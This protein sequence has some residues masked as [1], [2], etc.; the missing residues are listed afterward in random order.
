MKSKN[1]SFAFVLFLFLISAFEINA[2]TVGKVY[3]KQAADSIY[4]PVLNSTIINTQDLQSL[5]SKTFNYLMFKVI[6]DNLVILDDNRNPI[7]PAD[8]S[9]SE[10]D[11]FNYCSVSKLQELISNGND[12]FTFVENRQ[13]VLTITNGGFTLEEIQPC[14]PYCY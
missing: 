3:T 10:Y 9:V 5:F 6:Q 2:Q 1:H 14:P 13:K 12:P 7:Y 8:F 4:G 11:V